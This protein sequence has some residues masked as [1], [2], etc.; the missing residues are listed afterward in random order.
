MR[1]LLFILIC[2]SFIS[3]FALPLIETEQS[4]VLN[5]QI[6]DNGTISLTTTNYACQTDMQHLHSQK[7]IYLSNSWI[8]G[9]KDRRD[10]MGR[11][12]YWLSYPPSQINDQMV[13]MDDPLWT[14]DLVIV[15]DS[16]T[17]V[18]FEGDMEIYELLPAYNPLLISNPSAAALYNT[19]NHQDRVL[20]SIMGNP[21]PLPFDPLNSTNFCFSIPQAGS[22]E[23]PGFITD[24]AYYYDY[25]PFG[26][27]GDRDLGNSS[28]RSTH[29][30]L[31][32]AVHQ[33][34]YSWN[35]QDHDKML[36]N[37]Y[38]VY[39][40]NEL[41]TIEDLAISHYVDAD[42]GPSSW[43]AEI[44]SDDVSGY[45]RGQGHEFAYT[46]D[47]DGDGGLSTMYI[48]SKLIIPDFIERAERQAWFWRVGDGPNDSNIRDLN[49]Y[50][51]RTSN[52]K[53]WLCTGRNPDY[54]KFSPLRPDDPEIM[55]FEQSVPNDTRFLNTM[56]GALPDTPNYNQTDAQ[57]N[58]THRLN[59]QPQKSI[60]YYTV[61]F[62][63]E[64][65]AE[66]KAR[67]L[68]IEAFLLDG[69]QIDPNGDL[70]CIPYLAPIQVQEPDT[71]NLTWYSYTNP[72]HFELS[73][74]EYGAPASTWNVSILP[75]EARTH[76]LTGLAG[77]TWY[78][79]KIGSVYFTP[80]EVYLESAI[81]LANLSYVSI[82]DA[83]VPTLP[84]VRN[85]PNPFREQTTLHYQLK[86]SQPVKIEIYNLKGQLLRVLVNESKAA[87]P[88]LSSWDAKDQTG[89][90]VSSGIYFYKMLAGKFSSTGKMVLLK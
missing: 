3:A 70:T 6:H 31:G 29:Y 15:Q 56:Y 1:R 53:Y 21:A 19:Y 52:E 17:T 78:E 86:E 50:T 51:P 64:S 2:L 4:R 55:E 65:L 26:T 58:Y 37:K 60:S 24:S 59:L 39:N 68:Q 47:F 43:G 80:E 33:E 38:T 48:A 45:V 10:E 66:L 67:S 8:S 79:I 23:T 36:I 40:T 18:G 85:Y 28:S 42:V 44:A 13:T 5:T 57:G 81:K 69:L 77:D 22:F 34:S 41:D 72:D 62:V 16:L 30:P 89:A 7:L 73:Y 63:G 61:L 11:L 46:R 54:S 49:P 9:R 90:R 14:N 88:H 82:E 35:L 71:F 12:L 25:C 32:L 20:R 87:G 27:T 76:S 75:P 84:L 83:L 74:K